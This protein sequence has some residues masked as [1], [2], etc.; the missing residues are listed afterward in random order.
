MAALNTYFVYCCPRII[1]KKIDNVIEFEHVASDTITPSFE[2]AYI[3]I[4]GC[5][6]STAVKTHDSLDEQL[7]KVYFSYTNYTGIE[8]YLG[9]LSHC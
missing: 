5:V 4:G 3:L 2:A 1:R 8:S 9:N 7:F 6:I